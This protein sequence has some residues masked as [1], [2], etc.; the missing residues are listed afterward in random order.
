[1]SLLGGLKSG[2]G[3]GS[4]SRTVPRRRQQPQTA[5][6]LAIDRLAAALATL[7]SA[8]PAP[9][10][11]HMAGLSRQR[12]SEAQPDFH[13]R[14]RGSAIGVYAPVVP[15]PV[16]SPVVSEPV[17]SALVVSSPAVLD[18]GRHRLTAEQLAAWVPQ[19]TPT[20]RPPRH[21]RGEESVLGET[22]AAVSAPVVSAPV[23]SAPVV[24]APVVSVPVVSAPVVSAPVV[25]VPVVLD[26]GRHRSPAQKSASH[27]RPGRVGVK[28]LRLVL[29]G[30]L[31][32]L[33]A[34]AVVFGAHVVLE[35]SS[36]QP[37]PVAAS[38]HGQLGGQLGELR[39]V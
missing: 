34:V 36:A 9:A 14:H 38:T 16:V 10:S 7:P 25:S 3:H 11:S 27:S 18:T 28:S 6:R 31:V 24:S 23:V 32:F 5:D 21:S 1:M 17:V 4:A 15:E 13:A 26:G 19:P 30:I 22:A 2:L 8:S 29:M 35:G 37:Q 12:A 33:V 39:S 20:T